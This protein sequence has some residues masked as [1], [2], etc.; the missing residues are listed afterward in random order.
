MTEV[1]IRLF[2]FEI[3]TVA[4]TDAPNTTQAV[5]PTTGAPLFLQSPPIVT[6]ADI[7]TVANAVSYITHADG[8]RTEGNAL[9]L[10]IKLTAEGA[11]K[12]AAATAKPTGNPIASVD[13]TLARHC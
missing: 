2:Q 8:S 4:A 3:F 5:D 9:C 7:D 13:F 12:M 1:V 10:D 6:T 11:A